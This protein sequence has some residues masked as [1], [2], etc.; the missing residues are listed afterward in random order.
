ML[1]QL[2]CYDHQLQME[3]GILG[4]PAADGLTAFCCASAAGA[5]VNAWSETWPTVMIKENKIIIFLHLGFHFS[6]Y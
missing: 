3:K 5:A 2:I 6:L 4:F 1:I